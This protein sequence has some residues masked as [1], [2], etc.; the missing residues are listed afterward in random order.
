MVIF[1]IFAVFFLTQ[2]YNIIF[3]GYAPFIST[4][5]KIIKKIIEKIKIKEDG[6]VY[7]LGCG[8]AGFLRELRKKYPLAKLVGFEYNFFPYLIAQ[9]Q[10]SLSGSKIS[11]KKKNI[12][13]VNL[14]EADVLYCY[15]NSLMMKKLEEKIK[16]EG[17]P[18]LQIVSYQFSFP[19]MKASEVVEMD[20]GVVY[21]YN[22]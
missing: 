14:G 7:E 15:L 19:T 6:A 20:R 22:L 16:T 10:N 8:D 17:K 5:K 9:I 4:K 1:I 3:R 12:F 21:F 18:G 11:I 2:F 13:K